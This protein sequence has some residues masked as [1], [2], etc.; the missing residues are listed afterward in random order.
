MFPLAPGV[1]T[2]H[3][4]SVISH[5]TVFLLLW[6]AAILLMNVVF[7]LGLVLLMSSGFVTMGALVRL[8]ERLLDTTDNIK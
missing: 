6:S 2:A 3:V 1:T 8:Q 5:V 4:M 7:W